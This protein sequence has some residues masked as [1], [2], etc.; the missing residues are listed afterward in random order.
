MGLFI[1]FLAFS[2]IISTSAFTSYFAAKSDRINAL[3]ETSNKISEL[4]QKNPNAVFVGC[5]WWANRDLEYIL[6]SSL[7]FRNCTNLEGSELNSENIYLVRSEYYNFEH[8]DLYTKFA[9]KCDRNIIFKRS[10]FIISRCSF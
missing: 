10:S 3:N 1:L 2:N 7:N 9:E 4:K 6:F 8:A 5:G